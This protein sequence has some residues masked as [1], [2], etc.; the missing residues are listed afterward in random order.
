MYR[1]AYDVGKCDKD[2]TGHMVLWTREG[3]KNKV[4]STTQQHH[5][6]HPH[7]QHFSIPITITIT[8]TPLHHDHTARA[9][10]PAVQH[11][12]IHN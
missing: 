8:T 1:N 3:D 9:Q 10:P 11:H 6:H 7:H 2:N 12:H 5:H 4:P